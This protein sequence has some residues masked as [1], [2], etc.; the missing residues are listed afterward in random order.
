M[1]KEF[2][3][4]IRAFTFLTIIPVKGREETGEMPEA[5]DSLPWFPLVGILIGIVLFLLHQLLQGIIVHPVRPVLILITWEILTGGLHLDGLGD[6]VD[7]IA[8]GG[9]KEKKLAAMRDRHFGAFATAAV[10]LVLLGKYGGLQSAPS[11]CLILAPVIGR[12]AMMLLA[13]ISHPA[14][15]E[16]IGK[17]YAGYQGGTPFVISTVMVVG[18]SALLGRFIGLVSVAIVVL[19]V[20]GASRFFRSRIGGITGDTFG[21]TCEIS[22]MIVLICVR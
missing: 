15:S 1:E 9:R 22:E 21:F 6:T 11:F 7:G 3:Q 18:V 20:L 17:D 19:F 13:R 10:V 14:D 8:V 4:F 2:R 5:S 16:G 12:W